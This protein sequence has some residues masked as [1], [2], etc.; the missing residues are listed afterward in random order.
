LEIVNAPV[1]WESAVDEK[2]LR[3]PR[4]LRGG[5]K[6]AREG[7]T[8][9]RDPAE[10]DAPD[11]PVGKKKRQTAKSLSPPPSPPV[12]RPAAKIPAPQT[13]GPRWLPRSKL[14]S[15]GDVLFLKNLDKQRARGRQQINLALGIVVQASCE[16]CLFQMKNPCPEAP[17][18]PNKGIKPP[19]PPP[20]REEKERL[21]APGAPRSDENASDYIPLGRKKNCGCWRRCPCRPETTDTKGRGCPGGSP[22]EN[23]PA[24]IGRRPR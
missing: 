23:N 3:A 10:P 19:P 17:R 2:S 5:E 20:C 1:T 18:V 24:Q 13:K 16:M 9:P 11:P 7:G 4:L 6:Y 14:K 8:I 21:K 15:P 12:R 22:S